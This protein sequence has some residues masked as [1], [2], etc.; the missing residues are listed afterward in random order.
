MSNPTYLSIQRDV[1]TINERLES[2]YKR[3]AKLKECRPTERRLA[4]IERLENLI[5]HREQKVLD[6][7]AKLETISPEAADGPEDTL[8]VSFLTDPITGENTGLSFTITD[9]GYD[10]TYIGGTPL[11]AR[12]TG[13][14]FY[15]GKGYSS[16]GTTVDGLIAKE[17]A[18]LDG[19]AT[20]SFSL[21]PQRINGDYKDVSVYLLD[22]N[23]NIVFSQIVYQNGQSML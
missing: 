4:R 17:Y 7:N 23:N 6:L 20:S 5:A 10:D 1:E 21:S 11:K 2:N 12:V 22:D 18:P 13:S 16:Y 19:E 9:S 15:N 14:G 3:L 8:D